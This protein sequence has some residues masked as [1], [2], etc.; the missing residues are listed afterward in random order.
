MPQ[1]EHEDALQRF[2]TIWNHVECGISII[3]AAT[4]EIIDINP[5]AARM[6]GDDKEKIIGKRCHQFICPAESCSCPIMDKGQ[7]VDRSERKFVKADGTMI[8][9][10][11]SVAKI[12][13][14]GRLALLESFT[15][16]STLKEAEAK[17]MSL[18]VAEQ[19][20][21]AKSNFLS[22]MSHEMRTPMNA[23]IGMSK[24]A[25][26]TDDTDKLKYC[27]SM[28]GNSAEHLL[29][30]IND[31]L[32]MSKIEA[33]KFDIHAA[34]FNLEETL[35]TICSLIVE[36]AGEK[37]L[38][39]SVD[40]GVGM[41]LRYIGD[42]LRLS[43]ILA[44]LLSNAV[45]FTPQGGR[46]S[47]GVREVERRGKSSVLRFTVTDTGIGMTREQTAK[48]FN[49]FEQ[50]DTSISRRFGGTGLG[51]AISKNIAEKMNGSISAQ[52]E[53]GKGSTFTVDIEVERDEHATPVSPP[54]GVI[55]SALRLLVVDADEEARARF[56]AMA[57]HFGFAVDQSASGEQALEMNAEKAH[58]L[59][60]INCSLPEMSA[61]ETAK[62]LDIA[63]KSHLI[64]MGSFREWNTMDRDARCVGVAHFVSTPLFPSAL[65]KVV[66][67]VLG[68]NASA[69][70]Q[71]P[72]TTARKTDLSSVSL[73]LAEDVP[74]NREIFTALL[75]NTGVR[76]DEAEDG[77][78]A[79]AK[80][81]QA[82]EK[83]DMIIMDVQMP[84]MDGFEATRAIRASGLP[85]AESIP[86]IA[87]TANVFREDI[88]K[89]L[90]C[91][92]NDHLAK[93][94]D[95]AEVVRK[96]A[97]YSGR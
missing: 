93:P 8:P 44:N 42:S 16:I 38:H 84:G 76:V 92:M 62:G 83:Y 89:C 14:K 72:E 77:Y 26:S 96:I 61:L 10:V 50:A 80:F 82:P 65:L 91:G 23:I 21:Q 59:V 34:P 43:Q 87:L 6:F 27:L 86:I 30:L 79:L 88:E 58:D 71:K 11:K 24:I 20:S 35:S 78:A 67:D 41:P 81:S 63:G 94:I 74:I 4:R 5:I 18:Q 12:Q 29:A 15:D 97:D 60:F 70:K 51:L 73:L 31:I 46:I 68:K 85:R 36:K 90:A 25:E 32:D 55:P 1:K 9:I 64:M 95:E 3:D 33:G 53:S 37:E 66:A 2:E 40:L 13:Y 49:A 45:K 17:L 47:M 69:Q 75:E 54:E 48:L 39:F 22:R 56:A 28:I 7:V 57:G 19:A 52:S